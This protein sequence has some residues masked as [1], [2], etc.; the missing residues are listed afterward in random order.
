[1]HLI[2]YD[3]PVTGGELEG[4]CGRVSELGL[5]TF[6]FPVFPPFLPPSLSFSAAFALAAANGFGV[7]VRG[8]GRLYG[9]RNWAVRLPPA[10]R[11]PAPAGVTLAPLC[12]LRVNRTWARPPRKAEPHSLSARRRGEGRQGQSA[13]T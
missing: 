6:F 8:G 5:R 2:C 7:G 3:S 4:N 13:H 9:T 11:L 1:M 12:S 10:P